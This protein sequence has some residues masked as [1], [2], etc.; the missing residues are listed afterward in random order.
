[1]LRRLSA[2]LVSTFVT[3]IMTLGV[4]SATAGRLSTSHQ[5]IRV[6]FNN[7]EFSAEGLSTDTCHVTLE[8][9]LHTRTISKTLGVLVGYVTHVQTESCSVGTTIL[10]A[11]LPWHTTFNGFEGN[12]PTIFAIRIRVRRVSIALGS[13]GFICLAEGETE[14]R[15]S[16]NTSTGAVTAVDIPSQ[17]V[18]LRSGGGFGCPA[19]TGWLR[20]ATPGTPTVLGTNTS[21]TVTLI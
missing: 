7:V 16:R 5:N 2:F 17:N 14:A 4:T 20:T 11:S 19:E 12:L 8:G 15:G 10:T 1:M 18:A 3:L 21:I 13:F 6:T 9:S